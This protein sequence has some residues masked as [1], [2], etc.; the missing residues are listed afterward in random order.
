MSFNL[1]TFLATWFAGIGIDAEAAKAKLAEI[2]AQY[3][4]AELQIAALSSWLEIQLAPTHDV[5]GM[6]NTILGIAR[7]IVQG[8]AG[9]DPSAWSGSV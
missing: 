2:A 4:D 5:E 7:D 3:P 1:G 9:Q 6:R 8:T